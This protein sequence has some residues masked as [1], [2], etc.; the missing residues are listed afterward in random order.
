[1]S[2]QNQ[3]QH[4]TSNET[5]SHNP[6]SEEPERQQMQK[7]TQERTDAKLA[8]ILGETSS[9]GSGNKTPSK[10]DNDQPTETVKKPGKFKSL[11][12]VGKGSKEKEKER[13]EKERLEK[14]R[15]K[16]SA[17]ASSS[18]GGNNNNDNNDNAS[19]SRANSGASVSS[20]GA[21]SVQNTP[22]SPT[23]ARNENGEEI[24]AL[25]VYPGNVDFG[26]SMYKTVVVSPSTMASEVANQAVVKFKFA[27]D[28]A[29]APPDFYLTVRGVDGGK[30]H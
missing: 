12:G 24:I 26:A 17:K 7:R 10:D 21:T 2:S 3:R 19:R 4:Q 25:R 6:E 29:A 27:P 14:E 11:F 13:K 28:G 9:Q 1:M 20:I 5:A 15:Q 18:P 8:A 23:T 30:C 16:Q 22:L